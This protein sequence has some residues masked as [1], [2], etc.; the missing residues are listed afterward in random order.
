[1]DDQAAKNVDWAEVLP[2]D[3]LIYLRTKIDNDGWYPMA[4]FERMGVAILKHLDGATLDAVRLW[5]GSREQLCRETSELVKQNSPEESLMR[6]KCSG[7]PLRFSSVRLTHAHRR[8]RL[9]S[10][11]VPHGAIAE[12]AACYQTLGFC[13]GVLSLAALATSE[14]TLSSGND[15]RA[16]TLLDLR[17]DAPVPSVPPKKKR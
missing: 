13:E 2:A 6:L 14:V 16:R 9:C 12:E 7:A 8:S 5:D 11:Y 15:R 10:R 4:A 17:W 3:D 1:L